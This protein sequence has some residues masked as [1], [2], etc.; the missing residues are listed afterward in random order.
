MEHYT[1]GEICAIAGFQRAIIWLVF[2]SL[3]EYVFPPA[4]IIV[5]IVRLVFVYLLAQELKLRAAWAW[6]LGM[7]IPL[8]NI[9]LL[10]MLNAKATA[11]I[12]NKGI[13]VGLMGA[14]KAQLDGL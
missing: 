7:I 14:N 4:F 1:N 3:I 2:A 12:R 6:C 5:F 13:K 10:L 8:V 11:A 9:I